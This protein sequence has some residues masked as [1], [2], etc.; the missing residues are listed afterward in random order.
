MPPLQPTGLVANLPEVQQKNYDFLN[1]I[2]SE[3]SGLFHPANEESIREKYTL[4]SILISGDVLIE[5]KPIPPVPTLE[6]IVNSVMEYSFHK[7]QDVFL[8]Q[9]QNLIKLGQDQRG[10]YYQLGTGTGR[11]AASVV[12]SLGA[13][14]QQQRPSRYRFRVQPQLSYE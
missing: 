14:K 10:A 13:D 3:N 6:P 5:Y 11:P 2:S 4:D 1:L 7:P 8:T 9:K 12:V